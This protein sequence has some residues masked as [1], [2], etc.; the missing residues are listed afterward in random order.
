M[1]TIDVWGY[2]DNSN[3]AVPPG[4]EIGMKFD[5]SGKMVENF[6]TFYKE[7]REGRVT[8]KPAA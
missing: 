2:Y 7:L 8:E 4:L 1:K 3:G 6:E 5:E